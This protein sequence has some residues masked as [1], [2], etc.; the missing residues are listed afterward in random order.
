MAQISEKKK[1]LLV[2][3]LFQKCLCIAMLHPDLLP[4]ANSSLRLRS[5]TTIRLIMAMGLFFGVSLIEIRL[6]SVFGFSL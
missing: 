1:S 5:S 6:D 3:R 2:G 4:T